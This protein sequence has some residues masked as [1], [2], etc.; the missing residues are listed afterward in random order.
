MKIL[1]LFLVFCFYFLNAKSFKLETTTRI[2]TTT[3][4]SDDGWIIYSCDIE[5]N[6][7]I[8]GETTIISCYTSSN[9]LV[10]CNWRHSGFTCH[11]SPKPSQE[12]QVCP[13]NDRIIAYHHFSYCAIGIMNTNLSDNGTWTFGA[14]A[15]GPDGLPKYESKTFQLLVE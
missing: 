7:Q 15:T 10:H 1:I 5:D 8:V 11:S 9:N 6:P 3:T 4:S 2:T 14:Y 13:E 12:G